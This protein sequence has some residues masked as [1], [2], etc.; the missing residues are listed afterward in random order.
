MRPAATSSRRPHVDQTA[1]AGARRRLRFKQPRPDCFLKGSKDTT[2]DDVASCMNFDPAQVRQKYADKHSCRKYRDVRLI[3]PITL[4]DL[5]PPSIPAGSSAKEC[6]FC[7]RLFDTKS[8]RAKHSLGCK[9]MPYSG[10]L[11][12]VR[13]TQ[14]YHDN[15]NFACEHCG[16]GFC[17]PKAAGRHSVECSRRRSNTGLPL[18]LRQ[19]HDLERSPA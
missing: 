10:W 8:E 17:T 19:W 15:R 7:R 11:Y 12:R 18:H 16:T 1:L 13:F 14:S 2:A 3:R 5:P 9:S 6:R 4:T